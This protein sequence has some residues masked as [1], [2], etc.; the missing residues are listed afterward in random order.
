MH[1]LPTFGGL[2]T[3][4]V[5]G[6]VTAFFQLIGQAALYLG[7]QHLFNLPPN[8]TAKQ[9]LVFNLLVYSILVLVIFFR[10]F[11]SNDEPTRS[12]AFYRA[13]IVTFPLPGILLAYA[14]QTHG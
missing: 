9:Y 14:W 12:Q 7:A 4:L 1:K 8:P 6:G 2:V 10:G 13:A 3:G 5:L 11:F